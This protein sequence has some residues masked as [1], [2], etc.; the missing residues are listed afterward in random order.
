MWSLGA[1]IRCKFSK[2]FIDSLPKSLTFR[3]FSLK[4]EL[5]PSETINWNTFLQ[6]NPCCGTSQWSEWYLTVRSV[7]MKQLWRCCCLH[8]WE[9]S[10]RMSVCSQTASSNKSLFGERGTVAKFGGDRFRK[11]F[12]SNLNLFPQCHLALLLDQCRGLLFNF[13]METK[14]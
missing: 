1:E 14:G 2:C 5:H 7:L 9:V 8:C 3:R 6:L 10:G 12:C 13:T 11:T 4:W